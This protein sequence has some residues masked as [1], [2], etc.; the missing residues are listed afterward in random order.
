MRFQVPIPDD[1]SVDVSFFIWG[2]GTHMHYVGRDMLLT[3]EHTDGSS[4]CLVQ[5][6]A[7]DFNW[8]RLYYYDSP[9]PNV[10]V[11]KPGDVLTMR[12]TYDNSLA[13]PFVR[14]ALDEQGLT[15]PVPVELGEA[16]LDEMCLSVFG[17]AVDAAFAESLP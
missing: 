1:P 14:R 4:E 10:P 7:W 9:V 5:T 15:E 8:Q 13:N 2:S 6:P 16:S 3:L 17:V 11:G 12:C